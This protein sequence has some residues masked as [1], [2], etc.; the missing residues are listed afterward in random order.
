MLAAVYDQRVRSVAVEEMLATWV[1]NEEFR[2]IGLA[3]FIPRILTLGDMPQWLSCLAPRPVLLVNPVDGRRR[4]I[5]I[6]EAS[7]LNNY[8]GSV[9]ARHN[10][11]DHFRQIESEAATDWIRKWVQMAN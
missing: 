2:D 9:F 6:E 5:S 11:G 3:Y 10:A 8:P 7:R 1:F 4:R